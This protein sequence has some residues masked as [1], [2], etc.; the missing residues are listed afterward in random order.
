MNFYL[1]NFYFCTSLDRGL[2][3]IPSVF[4]NEFDL[5]KFIL[6]NFDNNFNA[7]NS[8]L[9]LS[10]E[11]FISEVSLESQVESTQNVNLEP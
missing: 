1:K 7:F 4:L 6:V 9:K 2:K 10:K 11:R 5:F 8:K 3:F